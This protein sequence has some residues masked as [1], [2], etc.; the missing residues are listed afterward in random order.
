MNLTAPSYSPFKPI[1][2]ASAS[3]SYVD[4]HEIAPDPRLQK[5]IYCYWTLKSTTVLSDS[6]TYRVV[7]DG[8]IDLF[9]E[10]GIPGKSYVM[11]L[12]PVSVSFPLGQQFYYAGIRFLPG[13]FPLFARVN[14]ADLTGKSEQLDNICADTAAYLSNRIAPKMNLQTLKEKLDIF[15]LS[16]FFGM[17][18]Q[19]DSRL[20][21]AIFFIFESK[22]N[23]NLYE[24][25]QSEI[26]PRQLRRLFHTYI[27][28]SPKI[29]SNIVRFQYT[30][31]QMMLQDNPHIFWDTGYYDQPHFIKEFR[32]FAGTTPS[33]L[34]T[35]L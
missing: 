3:Y 31:N 13:A 24:Q 18:E 26:S 28:E 9:F 30:L 34:T 33:A 10:P 5:S 15:F 12:S 29:F 19:I 21:H 32:R 25:L 35:Q 7:S 23:L 11:G 1:Q 22:G 4:Y 14:A 2:P 6:Y 27:G 8:C 20:L 17:D 16:R